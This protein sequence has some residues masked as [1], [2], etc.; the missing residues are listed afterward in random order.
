MQQVKVNGMFLGFVLLMANSSFC[1]EI[2]IMQGMTDAHN[3]VRVG[4]GL[5]ALSWSDDLARIAQE[6]A[7]Y[8]AREKGCAMQHRPQKGNNAKG[9]GENLYW[10]SA[11]TWSY[12]DRRIQSLTPAKVVQS[13][14]MEVENYMY[15]TNSCKAG[16]VCGHY[17]QIV[18]RQ[19][20][21]VGCARAVCID[22]SQVW[23]CNYDPPGNLMG[24]KPY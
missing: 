9:Y 8:L 18:W 21:K 19:T 5:Q 10:A 12:G 13:W 11:I 22:N 6:W 4:F 2:G 14:V 24:Y 17:I 15:R 23:V 3:A 20:E 7:D 16:K 1:G